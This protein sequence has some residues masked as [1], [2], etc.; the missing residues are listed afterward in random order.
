MGNELLFPTDGGGTVGQ[1]E[2]PRLEQTQ[3]GASWYS[4]K[5][6][7][8]WLPGRGSRVEVPSPFPRTQSNGRALSPG[9]IDSRRRPRQNQSL[10]GHESEENP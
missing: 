5:S 8:L 9:G 3:E 1:G 7:L 2:E 10:K 4:E 6:P